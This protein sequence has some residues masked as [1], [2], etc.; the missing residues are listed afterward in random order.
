[1]G[2]QCRTGEGADGPAFAQAREGDRIGARS[3][4][5]APSFAEVKFART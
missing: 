5:N 1:M 3:R 2:E 4:G